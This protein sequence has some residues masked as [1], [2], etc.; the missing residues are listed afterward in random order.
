MKKVKLYVAHGQV[1][2]DFRMQFR[3]NRLVRD[4]TTDDTGLCTMEDKLDDED[5]SVDRTIDDED[6]LS[7]DSTESE[8]MLDQLL[9]EEEEE[10]DFDA[11]FDD[12]E[13]TEGSDE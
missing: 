10:L 6:Q 2:R 9:D 3:I 8:D 12:V 4:F 1:A 5:S 13:F 11:E 7:E